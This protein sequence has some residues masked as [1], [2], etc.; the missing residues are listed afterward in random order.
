MIG[1]LAVASGTLRTAANRRGND[2]LRINACQIEI[3]GRWKTGRSAEWK[4]RGAGECL[5]K[6]VLLSFVSTTSIRATEH[7]K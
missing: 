6:P 5:V 3:W 2:E 7:E 4:N 1:L